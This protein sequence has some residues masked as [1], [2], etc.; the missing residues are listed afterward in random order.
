MAYP[1]HRPSILDRWRS[2]H[3]SADYRG[4]GTGVGAA[5]SSMFS[6]VSALITLLVVVG[7]GI[8][9]LYHSSKQGAAAITYIPPTNSMNNVE[10]H[11]NTKEAVA[12]VRGVQPPQFADRKIGRQNPHQ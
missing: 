2:A 12:L 1:Q 9:A 4:H 5:A 8:A 3:Q 6:W 11:V 7:S 10:T